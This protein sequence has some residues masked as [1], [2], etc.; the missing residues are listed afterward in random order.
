MEKTDYKV[1]DFYAFK[2]KNMWGYFKSQHFSFWMIC[3]Y[4]FFEFVK[5][6]GLFPSIDILPWAQLFLIGS[7]VG[8]FIDPSVKWVPSSANFLIISFSIMILIS[9]LFATYPDVSKLHLID[10]YGWL[11]IYFIIINIVKVLKIQ[12]IKRINKIIN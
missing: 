2:I 9:I 11:L 1:E 6:Q 12:K 7:F 8:A 4:L 5:P 10:F 3:G